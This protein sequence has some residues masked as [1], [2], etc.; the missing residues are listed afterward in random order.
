[1]PRTTAPDVAAAKG[2]RKIVML[3][4][5][6]FTSARLA[7]AAGV[8]VILVGDSLAMVVL[9][10]DDT[11]SVTMEE[12]L[13]HVRAV[14]RGA[15]TAL[16]VAD[17]PFMSYQASVEMAVTNAGRFLKEGR[18][19]AVKVEGGRAIVPQV[20]AMVAAGIPVLGHVGLT[21][22][23]VA[24]LGGFKVQ[25]KTAEAAAELVADAAALAEAGC[26]AV[27]LECIPAPVAAAVTRTVPIPTI[28]I[29]AG[30]DCDGQVLVFHDVLG[31]YDRMRPRFVKQFGELGKQA[32]TA[33]TGYAE[34]V[35]NSD[36]PGAEHSFSMASEAQTAFEALL[37]PGGG[38][39]DGHRA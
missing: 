10:H 8:D 39:K 4:A 13:H 1:M 3:A 16:V 27:V 36:F 9:G 2:V 29:G 18:A 17:M 20:R 24:A 35:R 12:M 22:Q 11:L 31:L 38:E 37:T 19:G 32:V 5:Y 30:P 7:E 23:H 15:G 33:L 6:D 25:S 14:A 26:F 34:A 21:P 28:G